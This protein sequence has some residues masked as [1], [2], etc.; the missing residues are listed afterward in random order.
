MSASEV[1][2]MSVQLWRQKA[3]EGT[4]TPE[5]MRAAIAQIRAERIGQGAV[6][7]AAKEKKA[8]AAKKKEPINSDALL[9]ELGL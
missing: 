2:T 7:T 1:I 6:S 4:L 8:V 3:R 9:G 5:E